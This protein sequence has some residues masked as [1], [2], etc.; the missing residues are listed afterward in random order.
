[1]KDL[2]L[3][4]LLQPPFAKRKILLLSLLAAL[5]FFTTLYASHRGFRR[6][7][8]FWKGMAPLVLRYKTLKFKARRI[9]RCS[10]DE[11]QRRIANYRQTTAPQLVDLIL[12]L[13]GI[14]VKIGQVLSTIG[15]GLLPD[16]Y[17]RALRPLQ[18]G[19][20]PRDFAQISRIVRDALG[21]GRTLE[22]V[23][24]EFEQR[25]LGAASIAQAHRA[26]LKP[27]SPDGRPERVIVKVQYPEVARLFRADLAN[28]ELAAR[29]FAPENVEVVRALRRRHENELDF[30]KEARN[31]EECARHMREYGMEPRRV[32]I[33]RVR[34]ETG[35]CSENVLVMEYLEGIS[36]SDAIGSEQ[37]RLARALGREDGE[38]L[39]RV[40]AERMRQH[41]EKGGGAG[42]GAMD[43]MLGRKSGMVTGAV[44][45]AA[46]GLLRTYA[47]ARD[48]VEDV[49]A[50]LERVVANI[51]VGL[52]GTFGGHGGGDDRRL[53][54]EKEVKRQAKKKFEKVN[55]SRV[56]KTLV[57]VHGIQMLVTGVYNADPHPGNVLVLPDG[58]LGLL[59]YGMVGRLSE[60]HRKTIAQTILALERKD[61]KATAQIYREN[62]YKATNSKGDLVDDN[63][64]HRF[65]SFH[66]DKIDLSPLTLENGETVNI[67]ELLR[68]TREV[69]TPTWVEEGRRLAGLLQGVAAQA[70][71]PIS[72]AKE[73]SPIAKQAL[74]E[75]RGSFEKKRQYI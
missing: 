70:A 74:G 50:G 12:R 24:L 59:D 27:N 19:V 48:R 8:H 72:L 51:H 65:A 46:G 41:F 57:E 66:F 28:L 22:D 37:D 42:S 73:W 31:L 38:E 49:L 17:L 26:V 32:R 36:L 67:L 18:D 54:E 21:D 33:P 55:L 25:P 52:G 75:S 58:K 35:I 63:V 3:P 6:T 29:L 61:K 47:K 60:S 4:P 62:G 2:L 9:D 30:R 39:K 14:Y 23:F 53:L 34:N 40:L 7:L 1:M 13:G 44:G 11:L 71:R 15:Q 16:E 56:L 10:D 68:S 20:P 5:L 43:N 45:S 64:L 69:A